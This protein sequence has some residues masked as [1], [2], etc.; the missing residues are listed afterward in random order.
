MTAISQDDFTIGALASAAGVNVET[1]RYYQRRQ[2]LREPEREFG[3]VRRYC[4][5]DVA[6]IRFIKAGQRMGFRLEEIAGLLWLEDG[7]H[8]DQARVAAEGKLA[9][10]QAKIADLTRIEAALTAL[11]DECCTATGNIRCP[12]IAAL[13]SG[14]L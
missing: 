12:L 6:R 11:I 9:D 14:R 13:T 1:V 3:R 2:L 10:V 8:C 7:A 4:G 5:A